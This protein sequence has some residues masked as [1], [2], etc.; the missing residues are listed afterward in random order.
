MKKKGK[1]VI[2]TTNGEVVE[3]QDSSSNVAKNKAYLLAKQRGETL[4]VEGPRWKLVIDPT[5]PFFCE[6]ECFIYDMYT[7][8]KVM[9]HL[10]CGA[11]SDEAYEYA[12]ASARHLRHS[13]IVWDPGL[14]EIYR[15]TPSGRKWRAP[16]NWHKFPFPPLPTKSR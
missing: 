4:I 5:K 12:C 13:V 2:M 10:P 9:D 7:E 14:N 11:V 6:Y 16:K 8:A 1:Y 3:Y 15:V